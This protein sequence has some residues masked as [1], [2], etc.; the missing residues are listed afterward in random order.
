MGDRHTHGAPTSH[1]AAPARIAV[2]GAG[3]IGGVT[4]AILSR[5]GCEVEVVCKRASLAEKIRS[6]GIELRGRLGT[7]H[8][9]MP[10]VA[11]V[12]ELSSRKDIVFLATKAQ[13]MEGPARELIPYL[14]EDSVVVSLQ[15]GL[16]VDPLAEIVGRERVIGCVVGWG[17]VL[18]GEGIVEVTSRGTFVVGSPDGSQSGR[19]REVRDLLSLV[20]P[21]RVTPN[22]YGALYSKLMINACINSIGAVTGLALAPMLAQKEVP[23]LFLR[24]LGEARAV[25]RAAGITI[26]PYSGQFNLYRILSASGPV[27]SLLRGVFGAL[28]SLLG[29]GSVRSSTLQSLERG[30]PTEIDWLNGSIVALGDRHG[31]DAAVNRR[32][33]EIVKEVEAGRREMGP[34][35]L[36]ELATL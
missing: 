30:R 11:G 25:A 29:Y 16:C 9:V 33:V 18:R 13:D 14:E 19:L 22:I 21:T 35:N 24:I 4:A 7:F 5:A 6:T 34:A 20:V 32:I 2:V 26:E 8:A 3:S 10:A 31:V 1:F 23:P 28:V 15:N 27:S 36:R 17:G 12:R